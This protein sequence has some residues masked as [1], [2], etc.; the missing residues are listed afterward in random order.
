MK[1]EESFK[2]S[3]PSNFIITLW[4]CVWTAQILEITWATRWLWPLLHPCEVAQ[5][6]T[7]IK[8][9]T[10]ALFMA[11][12]L[13]PH[14]GSAA[15][16]HSWWSNAGRLLNLNDVD[17]SNKIKKCFHL[18][19]IGVYVKEQDGGVSKPQAFMY[20]KGVLKCFNQ[21]NEQISFCFWQLKTEEM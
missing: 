9:A 13:L 10:I 18:R 5:A 1:K 20:V 16:S 3:A 17:N 19:I 12:V 6:V 2:F 11:A 7:A 21:F 14:S 8:I 15:V 4:L